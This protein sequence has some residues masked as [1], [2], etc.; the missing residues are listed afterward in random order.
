MA[1]KKDVVR[2]TSIWIAFFSL[3]A[4]LILPF[5][6]SVF[7]QEEGPERQPPGNPG[8][9]DLMDEFKEGFSW[10]PGFKDLVT[11]LRDGFTYVVKILPFGTTQLPSDSTQ[12]PNNDF[13]RIPRYT[14]NLFLRPDLYLRYRSLK[15]LAKPRLEAEWLRWEDGSLEGETDTDVETFFNEWLASLRLPK[16]LFVS[17]GRENLQWGPSFFVSPSNPFFRDNGRANPV[18]EIPGMD[19]ARLVWVPSSDWSFSFIANVDEG[20]QEFISEDFES[21][22]LLATI[23][24]GRREFVGQE[25]EPTYALKADYTAYRKFFSVI[26][27]YRENDRGRLGGFAGWTVSDALFVYGEGN[28]SQ[29]TSALYPVEVAMIPSIGFPIIVMDPIEEEESSLEALM[30]IGGSYTLEAGPTLTAEYVVNTAGYNDKEAELYFEFRRQASR[31]FSL[32]D[33]FESLGRLG[34]A[35]TLDPGLRLLRKNYLMLQYTHTQIRDVFNLVF[36]YTVNLDDYSS[37]LIPIAQMDIS[38]HAQLFAIGG[39]NFGPKD[40]EFTSLADYA[41]MFGLEYT[42]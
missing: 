35:Q 7:A 5:P 31:V 14:G 13:L 1:R 3:W 15:L 30:L 12:N 25:F 9:N 41:V 17:Y 23:T 20:R 42:F 27:S 18:R 34:L 16:N 32:P 19:F 6:R 24:R 8:A 40:T 38:D 10:T 2:S 4:L 39:V 28:V 29:G 21:P 26:A 11:E 36:R 37:Q 22:P 33:P